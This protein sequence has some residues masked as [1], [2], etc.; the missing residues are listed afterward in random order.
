MKK[1][2]VMLVAL[3]A[4]ATG[5]AQQRL[6]IALMAEAGT[7]D[8]RISL[9][10][11]DNQIISVLM[12]PLV[13]FGYNLE[14]EPRLATAWE[15][16]EDGLEYTFELRE[17][18]VFHH[19]KP[20]TAEDVQYTY[21]WMLDPNNPATYR[22]LY[23]GIQSVDI[24]DDYTVR[25]TLQQPNA[26]FLNNVARLKIVPSDR[27]DDAN[28]ATSP[29]GT[30][31][32]RLVERVADD[33]TVVEKNEDYWGGEPRIDQVVFRPIPEDATRLLALEA[34]DIDLYQGQINGDDIARLEADDRFVAEVIA[35]TGHIYVGFNLSNEILADRR[36][37]EAFAHLLDRETIV[38]RVLLGV[39]LPGVSMISPNT[40]WFNPDVEQFPYNPERARELLEDAGYGEGLTLRFH[41]NENPVRVRIA[42]VLQFE[43][44]RIGV[45]LEVIV[46]EFGAFW[47]RIIQTDDFELFF[48]G[49]TGNVDPNYAMYNLFK[50][51]GANNFTHYANSRVD[52]LL[53]AGLVAPPFSEESREIYNEAQALIV[54]DIPFTFVYYIA[55]S[56][57]HS[58]RVSNWQV[59]PF[60]AATFQNLHLVE[61]TP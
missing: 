51:D 48:G 33:R 57:A 30:G 49:W 7:L 37:R 16:S 44:A 4:L 32:Y 27:G 43:A 29:V 17:G 18:V 9:S 25:F 14:L 58:A 53:E 12:E 41:M 28:F 45:N 11:Y 38:D 59:H 26:F 8:P 19:G 60:S 20:F 5:F 61:K 52:E 13:V 42:E 10:V 50:S 21:E 2:L 22:D 55:E 46:E 36:V 39:G 40:E 35:G 47:D 6:N 34:G 1:V 3:A 23:S 54:S 31:P 56:G 24:I 15:I